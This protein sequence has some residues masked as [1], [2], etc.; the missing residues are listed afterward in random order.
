MRD[1]DLD[2]MLEEVRRAGRSLP[3]IQVIDWL[4]SA[5]SLTSLHPRQVLR[6]LATTF[7]ETP[8]YMSPEALNHQGYRSKSDIW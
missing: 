4:I 3:K 6:D 7:T 5:A 2:C 1:Q 8:S